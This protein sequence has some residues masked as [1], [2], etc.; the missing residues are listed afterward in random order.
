MKKSGFVSIIGKPNVGKS[1]LIN[2]II[3][4]KASIVSPKPQTTRV[5]IYGYTTYKNKNDDDIQIIL[6]DTPGY[7]KPLNQLSESM[8]NQVISSLQDTDV[9]LFIVDA[10]NPFEHGDRITMEI[11]QNSTKPK[12]LTINKI[13]KLKDRKVVLNTIEEYSNLKIF[14]EIVPISALKKQNIDRLLETIEKYL[15]QR[16][17]LEF[18]SIQPFL[19]NL[20]FYISE[21]IREKLFNYTYKELPYKTVV[22][23]ETLE[24][25]KNNVLYISAVIFVEKESQKSIIIGKNGKMIKKLG[26]LAREE[27][28]FL[29][30]KKVY[31]DLWVK[32]KENWTSNEG[33]LKSIGYK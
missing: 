13:D 30:N 9:I 6:I 17:H 28:Q 4:F 31:I 19:A 26:T 11:F 7:H 24:E 15:P 8:I 21:I 10:T 20:K 5:S 27:L 14:D 12:I 3:N 2:N 22:V 25:R 1:T 16:E 29:L 23:V 32:E 33:F 18:D